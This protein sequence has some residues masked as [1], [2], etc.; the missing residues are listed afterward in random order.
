MTTDPSVDQT[1]DT[2]APAPAAP[3]HAAQL[4]SFWEKNRTFILGLCAVILV[5]IIGRE[6]WDYFSASREQQLSADY[7]AVAGQPD[8]LAKFAEEHAGHALA[9]V[10]W[11][12]LADDKYSAGDYKTAA[13]NYQKA[14]NA[15]Q[16]DVLKGRAKLGA[17]MSQ[18]AGGDKAAG[19]A[20]LKA[21]SADTS[22]EK[23]VRA[24][25]TYHLAALASENGNAEEAI[26]LADEVSKIDPIGMWAQR[27]FVL[28]ATLA[29][30]APAAAAPGGIQFKPGGE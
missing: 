20:A 25:A 13:A 8:K 4:Q 16:V 1:K 11:L 30:K 3:D 7:A 18:I 6:G 14:A 22:L 24:E 9:G 10:A 29:Q 21:L 28:R 15:L 26:K 23:N 19:E 17:A 12:R 27:S 5:V 2:A